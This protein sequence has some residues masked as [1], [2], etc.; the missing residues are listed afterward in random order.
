LTAL[1]LPSKDALIEYFSGLTDDYLIETFESGTLTPL[2]FEVA[3]KELSRRGLD[4]PVVVANKEESKADD[5]EPV[6][7]E[8]IVRSFKSQRLEILRARLEAEG[9]PAFVMDGNMNQTSSLV[10]VALGGARLQVPRQYVAKAN[11]ILAAINSGAFAANAR[12]IDD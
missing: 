1:N 4:H 5:G 8:T 11:E 3:E 2:A 12:D 7:L 9:I 6:I 10:S